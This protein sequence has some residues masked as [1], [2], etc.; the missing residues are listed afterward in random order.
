[1]NRIA[2]VRDLLDESNAVG[3]LISSL[4]HIRWACGF[5]GSNAVVYL[6]RDGGY[7]ITDGRYR[8][9]ARLE[10]DQ[11]SVHIAESDFIAFLNCSG[12]LAAGGPVLVQG[13]HLSASNFDRLRTAG[14]AADFRLAEGLLDRLVAVKTDHEVNLI[15]AAQQITTD[16]FRDLVD[17]IS[18]GLTEKEI[19]ARIICEHLRRGADGMSFDPIVASGPN[20]ALP[21]ARPGDRK[22]RHGDVV[23]LDFGCSLEGYCSDMTRTI[24]VGEPGP[25]A[26]QVF[27]VVRDAQQNAI[28]AARAGIVAKDLDGLARDHIDRSGYGSYFTHGLGHGVGMQ[29]HEWPRVSASSS[30]ELPTDVVI[31]IEPGVYIPGKFG[32]RIEDLVRLDSGGCTNLTNVTTEFLRVQS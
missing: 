4:P 12:W 24:A 27:A 28:G 9:Q 3:V 10:V 2:A 21:H 26:E 25:E 19:A 7:L 29:V 1:M 22:I 8:E 6:D 20:S 32:I 5:T 23:V 15:K 14:G 16:V 31:S 18:P 30:E 11:L 17:W 13:E